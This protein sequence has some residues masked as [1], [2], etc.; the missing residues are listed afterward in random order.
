MGIDFFKYFVLGFI[1]LFSVKTKQNTLCAITNAKDISSAV[2][3]VY[4]TCLNYFHKK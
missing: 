1:L 2:S 4:H 3:N